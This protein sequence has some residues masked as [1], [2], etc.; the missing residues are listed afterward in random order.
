MNQINR[1]SVKFYL[2]YFSRLQVSKS[3]KN[4]KNNL[5]MY[6]HVHEQSSYWVTDILDNY[7]MLMSEKG[8]RN[9]QVVICTGVILY[10]WEVVKRSFH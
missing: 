9:S 6:V 8:S 10:A 7:R 3:R 2:E 5:Q 1:L 4:N